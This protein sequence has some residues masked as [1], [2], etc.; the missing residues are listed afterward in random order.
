MRRAPHFS[1]VVLATLVTLVILVILVAGC[2]L[3]DRGIIIVNERVQNKHPVRFVEPTPVT[4]EA[5]NLCLA[6]L[7]DMEMPTQVCQPSD[8]SVA[9]PHFLDPDFEDDNGFR[10][11]FCSCDP[12]EVDTR[13]LAAVTLYVEDRADDIDEGLDPIY[14]ALQLDMRP[15]ETEP[16]KT[17]EYTS[18]VVPSA[19]LAEAP[20]LQYSPPLRPNEAAGRELRALNL[21]LADDPIDLCN[22]AGSVPLSR[23]FHTLRVIVTDAPWFTPPAPEKMPKQQQVQQFGVPDLAEG[24]TYDT[25]TYTFHCGDRTDDYCENQCQVTE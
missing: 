18:Y 22:G 12:P 2:V 8:P 14:A 24:A 13:K 16:Q 19:A 3:P 4:N 20:D 25:L 21:G 5:A 15:D 7:A 6:V 1:F 23:G 9:L 17:V 10:Y 11:R